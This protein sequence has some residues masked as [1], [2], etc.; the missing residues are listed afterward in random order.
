[1]GC[2]KNTER[3]VNKSI[4]ALRNGRSR[5]SSIAFLVSRRIGAGG[6]HRSVESPEP[7]VDLHSRASLA[8]SLVCRQVLWSGRRRSR[9]SEDGHSRNRRYPQT[10]VAHANQ[11]SDGRR[12]P[13]R[14]TNP[15]GTT[16][17]ASSRPNGWKSA[18]PYRKA[19]RSFRH[20]PK[21][22]ILRYPSSILDL[23][24]RSVAERARYIFEAR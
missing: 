17:S 2:Q 24:W 12:E 6:L 20:S 9:I 8:R 21:P 1:V 22:G 10:V 23:D 11:G 7:D 16:E 19:I 13:G 15:C 3:L 18:F 5:S 14:A 4:R